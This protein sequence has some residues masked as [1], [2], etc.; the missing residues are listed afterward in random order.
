MVE[1]CIASLNVA[2][3]A[4]FI[5]TPVAPLAGVVELTVGSVVSVEVPVV[6]L[7]V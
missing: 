7:H 1:L 6:K 5:A 3:I 2:I 4:V